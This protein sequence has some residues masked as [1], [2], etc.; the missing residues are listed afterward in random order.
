MTNDEIGRLGFEEMMRPLP[1]M[2]F[3][4]SELN[5]RILERAVARDRANGV[6]WR[7]RV[8]PVTT[9][10]FAKSKYAPSRTI[11]GPERAYVH[12]VCST[13][14]PPSDWW[15]GPSGGNDTWDVIPLFWTRIHD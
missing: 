15:L 9:V 7:D 11:T 10:T 14:V 3:E 6:S 1:V 2:R 4:V 12:D 13:L 5:Q 8:V